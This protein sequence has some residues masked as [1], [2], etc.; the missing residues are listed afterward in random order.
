MTI[1]LKYRA[2]RQVKFFKASRESSSCAFELK[3]RPSAGSFFQCKRDVTQI[4][5]DASNV[6]VSLATVFSFM[7]TW[8]LDSE[9]QGISDRGNF[10]SSRVGCRVVERFPRYLNVRRLLGKV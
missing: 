5:P 8:A 3:R 10:F 9:P 1:V 2:V 4:E 7:V 6:A